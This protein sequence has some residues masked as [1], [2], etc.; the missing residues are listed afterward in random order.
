MTVLY[1]FGV[2]ASTFGFEM[3][4]RNNNGVYANTPG[5]WYAGEI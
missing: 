5:P 4:D 3:F 2:G 1:P